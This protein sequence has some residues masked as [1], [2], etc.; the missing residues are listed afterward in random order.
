MAPMIYLP[1]DAIV[2]I[3]WAFPRAPSPARPCFGPAHALASFFWPSS[4]HPL[5][6]ILYCLSGGLGHFLA[7]TTHAMGV[8]GHLLQGSTC[9]CRPM[10]SEQGK[11]YLCICELALQSQS[12]SIIVYIHSTCIHVMTATCA[13]ASPVEHVNSNVA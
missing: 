3:Y 2:A 8:A 1:C 4:L 6:T 13:L 7:A 12:S 5:F 9:S 11:V 10:K